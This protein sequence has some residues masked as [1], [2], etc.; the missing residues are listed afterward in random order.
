MTL[1]Q[2]VLQVVVVVAV[3]HVV[4]LALLAPVRDVR[5]AVR[6][7]ERNARRV[8]PT[9]VVLGVVLVAN[10]L[11]R[12]AGVHL[13]WLIGVNITPAIYAVEGRF[14]AA[15]QSVATPELTL[16]F[17]FVYVFGY[18][19]L[20]T[21]PVVLYGLHDAD[22]LATTLVAYTLNYAF[23]LVSYVLFVAYGPRNYMPTLVESLLYVRWPQ[24]QLLT[25][26][27]NVNTNVFPSLHASLAVTVAL[28]AYRY[29]APYRGWHVVAGG[30][31]TLVCLSTMYLGI[32]WLTDVVGGVLLAVLSVTLAHRLVDD[33][34][35]RP[36]IRPHLRDRLPRW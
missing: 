10:G 11:V 22:P 5:Q 15:V 32:H 27:V 13:S 33:D 31:A 9:A 35:D 14:V 30:L 8:A 1:L 17:G 2:V 20:L 34:R 21:F 18:A 6:T 23:G 26:Q 29:R 28:I 4:G 24:A 12:D 25:S 3:L 19:F 7:A 36:A 16:L